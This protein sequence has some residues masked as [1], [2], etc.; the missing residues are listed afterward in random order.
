MQFL[1]IGLGGFLGAIARFLM[2]KYLNPLVS[3]I[4]FG[5]FA[6]NVTGSFLMGLLLYLT[7]SGQYVPESYKNFIAI[8][9]L[10][11]FTT[12]STLAT[13]SFRMMDSGEFF[14]AFINLIFNV[15]F[16]LLAVLLGKITAEYIF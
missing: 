10:G 4:P 2:I 5:I 8:G 1:I 11:S 7:I 14:L 3:F 13:D 12:M 9:F 16:C 15:F 6:A